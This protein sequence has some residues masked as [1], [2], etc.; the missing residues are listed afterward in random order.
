VK[1]TVREYLTAQG[2]SPFPTWLK[3]LDVG[4]QARVLRFENGNPGDHK[5]VGGGAWEARL[6]FGPGYHLYFGKE[7]VSMILLLAGGDKASQSKDNSAAKRYW[8][9]FRKEVKHGTAQ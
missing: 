3:S 5:A 9:D 1:L 4:V 2:K 7:G 8:N 6:D